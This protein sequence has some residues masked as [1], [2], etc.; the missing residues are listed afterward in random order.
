MILKKMAKKFDYHFQRVYEMLLLVLIHVY[1]TWARD[2]RKNI[3]AVYLIL[4]I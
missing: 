3:R 2:K 1:W 4:L